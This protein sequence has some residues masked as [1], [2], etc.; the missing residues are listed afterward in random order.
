[1]SARARLEITI[2]Q[3]FDTRLLDLRFM[4]ALGLAHPSQYPVFLS[5]P[6]VSTKHRKI[7]RLVTPLC[8]LYPHHIPG[9]A[10]CLSL[11]C[12]AEGQEWTGWAGWFSLHGGCTVSG[13]T[14]ERAQSCVAATSCVIPNAS[15]FESFCHEYRDVCDWSYNTC[16]FLTA[17]E[18]PTSSR[19]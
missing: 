10:I 15:G 13:E 6:P 12:I 18:N 16:T 8:L 4:R 7:H 3:R 14:D 2:T 1:M 5:L 19:V 17:C 9:V 11:S